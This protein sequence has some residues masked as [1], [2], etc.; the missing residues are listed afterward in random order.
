MEMEI[1]SESVVREPEQISSRTS[2]PKLRVWSGNTKAQSPG[3][4]EVQENSSSKHTQPWTL[5]Q[6]R[7]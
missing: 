4:N 1:K 6:H 5:F 7:S 3:S 2:Q